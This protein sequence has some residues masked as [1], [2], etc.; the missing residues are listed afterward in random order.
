[1][2]GSTSL[3]NDF[4]HHSSF[5]SL[6]GEA[7]FHATVITSPESHSNSRADVLVLPNSPD[8]AGWRRQPQDQSAGCL[9]TM[10]VRHML[11]SKRTSCTC[12]YFG[13]DQVRHL[14]ATRNS[15]WTLLSPSSTLQQFVL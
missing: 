6:R 1:M 12:L 13:V 11:Y 3:C 8:I 14:W 2:L 7:I 9:N 5:G 15:S 4:S 10:H